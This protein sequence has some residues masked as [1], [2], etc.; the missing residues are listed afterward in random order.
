MSKKK[1]AGTLLDDLPTLPSGRG[2]TG[3]LK[4]MTPDQR[5]QYAEMIARIAR[6][7]LRPTMLSVS[8]AV[9]RRFGVIISPR[10]ITTHVQKEERN[11]KRQTQ[12]S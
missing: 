12:L 6:M 11:I 3:K 2:I 4:E 5:E 8:E 9:E 1:S 10:T 7:T